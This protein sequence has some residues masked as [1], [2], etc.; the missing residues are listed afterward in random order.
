[1]SLS[2]TQ[3]T[4][5]KTLGAYVGAGA[6]A[7]I[8]TS[9]IEGKVEQPGEDGIVDKLSLGAVIGSAGLTFLGPAVGFNS[10]QSPGKAAIIGGLL[11]SYIGA[12]LIHKD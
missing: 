12:Q 8:A 5:L 7:A 9:V 6:A 11:G 10:M 1:M 4:A 2:P 3:M